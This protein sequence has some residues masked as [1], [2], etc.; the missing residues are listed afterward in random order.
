MVLR[1]SKMLINSAAPTEL[2]MI[3]GAAMVETSA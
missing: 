1:S 3:I 2:A